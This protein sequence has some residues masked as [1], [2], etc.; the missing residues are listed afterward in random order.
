MSE[1][2]AYAVASGAARRR[3]RLPEP[4]TL[5]AATAGTRAPIEVG[6]IALSAPGQTLILEAPDDTVLLE[7]DWTTDDDAGGRGLPSSFT[8]AL[9]GESLCV[10]ALKGRSTEG[11]APKRVQCRI[12][13][14]RIV[15][16][17]RLTVRHFHFLIDFRLA[18]TP[19]FD[20][21]SVEMPAWMSRAASP[22]IPVPFALA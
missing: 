18:A 2:L 19:T 15:E 12:H 20:R 6:E 22:G 3:I 13:A 21:P 11:L 1:L 7:A 10:R 8:H 17:P 9:S 16:T 5:L 14:M 4:P